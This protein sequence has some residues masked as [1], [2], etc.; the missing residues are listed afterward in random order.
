MKW[1][2][3]YTQNPF[4]EKQKWVV[5]LRG[6]ECFVYCT[7]RND[8]KVTI[9]RSF[10]G[11]LQDIAVL[12]KKF[13]LDLK[14]IHLVV[15]GLDV[16]LE[17]TSGEEND[18]DIT[19]DAV[20]QSVVTLDESILNIQWNGDA[21]QERC[22]V[23]PTEFQNYFKVWPLSLAVSKAVKIPVEENIALLIFEE[24]RTQ[25]L[26]FQSGGLYTLITI[27]YGDDFR[28]NHFEQYLLELRKIIEYY[29]EAKLLQDPIKRILLDPSVDTEAYRFI[30][31][32]K[33]KVESWEWREEIHFT[34]PEEAFGMTLVKDVFE[35]DESCFTLLDNYSDDLDK[36]NKIW[37]LNHRVLQVLT[38]PIIISMII[39]GVL[40]CANY[41]VN[42]RIE[43]HESFI[44]SEREKLELAK[45][46]KSSIRTKLETFKGVVS[47]KSNFNKVLKEIAQL[48]PDKVWLQQVEN[49]S[50]VNGK[51]SLHI[52][53]YSFTQGLLKNFI[54]QLEH[55]NLFLHVQIKSTEIIS[56]KSIAKK[57]KV[58]ANKKDLIYFQL[59][60]EVR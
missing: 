36:Q 31:S 22:E 23:L 54:A 25:I 60:M 14:P 59:F 45:N 47:N 44:Q 43:Q 51:K 4:R 41:Y 48:V 58:R 33:C 28:V 56:G 7:E 16:Y 11:S 15:D 10:T 19:N 13:H 9:K 49:E 37:T 35:G 38:I 12:I 24:N 52:A 50:D 29:W 40:F 6:Q 42:G 32:S 8:G 30:L 26:F 2:D 57:T 1:F 55:S 20:Q 18:S 27:P 39:I 3:W 21:L 5:L 46:Y 17:H 53:G 34:H